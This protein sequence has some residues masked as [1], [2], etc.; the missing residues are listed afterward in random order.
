MVPRSR[1]GRWAAPAAALL[2]GTGCA[3]EAIE[4]RWDKADGGEA[5]LLA[6]AYPVAAAWDIAT[7][8]LLVVKMIAWD[9]PQAQR[10]QA[11]ERAEEA[12]VAREEGCADGQVQLHKAFVN[13]VGV[14][15]LGHQMQMASFGPKGVIFRVNGVNSSFR[16]ESTWAWEGV[17]YLQQNG[18]RVTIMGR[19]ES[20][21]KRV[22]MC[23]L[24]LQVR[25]GCSIPTVMQ[26]IARVGQVYRDQ[27]IEIR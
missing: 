8:P 14:G 25:K 18:D 15:Q 11:Q 1:V 17:R 26:Q 21:G 6:A 9:G 5:A 24:N 20:N 12:R 23:P 2:L 22:D 19:C 4:D 10:E 3:T 13:E 16:H 7:L 27:P